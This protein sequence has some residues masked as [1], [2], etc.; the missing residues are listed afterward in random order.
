MRSRNPSTFFRYFP[1]NFG[2]LFLAVCFPEAAEA[3]EYWHPKAL[4]VANIGP[5]GKLSLEFFLGS[6]RLGKGDSI[7]LWASLEASRSEVN[8]PRSRFVV[9]QLRSYVQENS[10]GDLVWYKPGNIQPRVF[11][12]N[13]RLPLGITFE[14][15]LN[16]VLSVNDNGVVYEYSNHVLKY[17]TFASGKRIVVIADGSDI[18]ELREQS[19]PFSWLLKTKWENDH[20][21]LIE[22]RNSHAV[23]LL[24][25][26]YSPDVLKEI[27]R[28][29]SLTAVLRFSYEESLLSMVQAEGRMIVQPVW[30]RKP[31]DFILGTN[32]SRDLQ[33][34]SDGTF[35]YKFVRRDIWIRM[36]AI[37][38]KN[39]VH[40]LYLDAVSGRGQYVRPN[41]IIEDIAGR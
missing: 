28:I 11:R 22:F 18:L 21:R 1:I 8:L 10:N 15:D 24:F 5:D 3:V 38:K 16:G 41:G 34:V 32:R 13:K 29:D 33:L 35:S 17:V 27:L 30:T 19:D 40:S 12:R 6:V 9:S 31:R 39:A 25:D 20:T 4:K 36:H 2:L 26:A 37:D 23:K 7:P 14:G